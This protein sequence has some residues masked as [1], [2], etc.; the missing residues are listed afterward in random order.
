[1]T[2]LD[3]GFPITAGSGVAAAQDQ[4][5]QTERVMP[6]QQAGGA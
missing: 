3:L 2:L 5:R 1:M 6:R 4:Y